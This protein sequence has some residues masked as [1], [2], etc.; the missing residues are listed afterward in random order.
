MAVRKIGHSRCRGVGL[1]ANT[2]VC[3]GFLSKSVIRVKTV[4]PVY[5]YFSVGPDTNEGRFEAQAVKRL[6][7]HTPATPFGDSPVKS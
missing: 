5:R 4:V 7:V 1:P 6:D 3:G 2:V